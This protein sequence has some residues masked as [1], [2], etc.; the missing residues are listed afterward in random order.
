[1]KHIKLGIAFFMGVA[2]AAGAN[3]RPPVGGGLADGGLRGEYFANAEFSGAPAFVRKDVRVGVRLGRCIASRRFDGG[4]VPVVST[5]KLFNTLDG[6]GV[7][8]VFRGVHVQGERDGRGA[9]MG[10][11]TTRREAGGDVASGC[12]GGDQ[13]GISLQDATGGGGVAVGES[14]HT[15]G[16]D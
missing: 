4:T 6:A 12:A 16:S 7:A 2:I 10:E 9:T 5:G 11:W 3:N 15:G 1:M 13:A 14:E 8:A